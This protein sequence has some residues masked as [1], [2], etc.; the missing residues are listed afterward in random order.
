M[1]L[2]DHAS[3]GC[4][5]P[6]AGTQQRLPDARIGDVEKMRGKQDQIESPAE[7]KVLDARAD[8]LGAA[9]ACQHLRR[10]VDSDDRMAEFGQ[11]VG[12]AAGS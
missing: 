11:R 3:G 10:F 2:D 7:R 6:R 1:M 5:M 4:Y 8:C 9:I 12:N